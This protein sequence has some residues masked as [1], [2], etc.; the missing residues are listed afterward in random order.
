MS[1]LDAIFGPPPENSYMKYMLSRDRLAV[2]NNAL[3][4]VPEWN[5]D[6]TEEQ[7]RGWVEAMAEVTKLAQVVKT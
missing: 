6:W 4:N 2:V 1:I 3:M 7:K 5:P